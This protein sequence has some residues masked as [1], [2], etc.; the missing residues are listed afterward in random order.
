MGEGDSLSPQP[1]PLKI[2]LLLWL[3]IFASNSSFL[4][5]PV[6]FPCSV[7]SFCGLRTSTIVASSGLK[8]QS[9]EKFPWIRQ[10]LGWMILGLKYFLF[11]FLNLSL[12]P[13]AH[14]SP[15]F[16]IHNTCCTGCSWTSWRT[17]HSI[18]DA[19]TGPAALQR[20]CR[21]QVCIF[22]F[23]VC[24]RVVCACVR[25]HACARMHCVQGG[26]MQLA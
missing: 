24:N 1:G 3:F 2:L 15:Y 5:R 25:A 11:L 18:S 16:L 10:L 23:K 7:I 8:S 19:L 21:D 4:H 14:S 17:R 9:H 13:D 22:V 20:V 6:W 26:G 12:Y